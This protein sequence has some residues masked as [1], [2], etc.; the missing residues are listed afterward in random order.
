MKSEKL[1]WRETLPMNN[2]KKTST[3]SIII[4]VRGERARERER[5]RS[6]ERARASFQQHTIATEWRTRLQ[7]SSHSLAISS[8]ASHPLLLSTV[9]FVTL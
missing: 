3:I 1:D 5:E 6:S 8:S 7:R 4:K 2:K 9:F